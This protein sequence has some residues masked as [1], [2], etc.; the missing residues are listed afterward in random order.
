MKGQSAVAHLG[1]AL[2]YDTLYHVGVA[3]A[4]C[5]LLV[6]GRGGLHGCPGE[7]TTGP[8]SGCLDVRLHVPRQ[9]LI[10]SAMRYGACAVR[11]CNCDV[12]SNQLRI[13]RT[14]LLGT[15]LSQLLSLV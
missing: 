12:I 4:S 10:S 2:L 6:D 3:A 15:R 7:L 1:V 11:V 8:H 14:R 13:S 9:L 5:S